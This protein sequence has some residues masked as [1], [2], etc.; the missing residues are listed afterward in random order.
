MQEEVRVG[1]VG[2]QGVGGGSAHLQNPEG[3]ALLLEE[4]QQ[5]ERAP[6][7]YQ[8]PARTRTHTHTQTV[9]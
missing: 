7:P 9:I 2:L 1:P 4:S 5:S 3:T 8:T 6:Q